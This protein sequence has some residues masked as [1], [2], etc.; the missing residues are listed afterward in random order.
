MRIS[1]CPCALVL[2]TLL[3]GLVSA[4][5][6]SALAYKEGF[7]LYGRRYKEHMHRLELVEV[8]AKRAFYTANDD[9]T[10]GFQFTGGIRVPEREVADK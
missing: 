1:F 7:N 9:G 2:T 3:G 6:H 4:A 8:R 10:V 5:T